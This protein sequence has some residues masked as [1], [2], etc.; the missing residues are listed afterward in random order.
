MSL[1]SKN[2]NIMF[3]SLLAEISS[4]LLEDI[5]KVT[6]EFAD[7][8]RTYNYMEVAET[9][10]RQ[11]LE[12]FTLHREIMMLIFYLTIMMIILLCKC[13]MDCLIQGLKKV[14]LKI[15]CCN[16]QLNMEL[17]NSL[18]EVLMYKNNLGESLIQF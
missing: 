8:V 11:V 18:E 17:R 5:P 16:K 10:Y 6:G 14:V 1:F 3:G 13:G 2:M 15:Q 12:F 9:V 7:T 4:G